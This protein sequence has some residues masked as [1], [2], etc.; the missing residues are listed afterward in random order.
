MRSRRVGPRDSSCGYGGRIVGCG[1][2]PSVT[3]SEPGGGEGGIV[4]A[5]FGDVRAKTRA[6]AGASAMVLNSATGVAFPGPVTAPPMT[7]TDFARRKVVGEWEA[8]RAR[9]VRGPM[10]MMVIVPGG[11]SS[12]SRRISR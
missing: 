10:A 3:L 4:V 11:F 8:A 9:L 5:G 1:P 7:R 2:P 12:R 6:A